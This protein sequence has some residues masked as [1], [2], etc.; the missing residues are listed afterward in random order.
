MVM[1]I[2]IFSFIPQSWP[3]GAKF[4][5][6][7]VLIPVIAGTSYELLRL[8]AKMKE[9]AL[10]HLMILPGLILQRLTTREPDDSQIEVAIKAVNEVL[11]LEVNSA[12][13]A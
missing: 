13:E 7:L 6:R 10:I 12:P 8:S 4:L 2:L 3:F 9:N 5:S 11:Q 1:S